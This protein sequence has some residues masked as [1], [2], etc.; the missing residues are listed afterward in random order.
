MKTPEPA[1][2]RV[3]NAFQDEH[4][5]LSNFWPAKVVLDGVTYPS[6]EHAYQ[7]AKTHP[8]ERAPF[9]RCTAAQA[10]KLG[11]EIPVRSGWSDEKVAIMRALIEQKFAPGSE[12]ARKLVATGDCQL[13]EGNSWGDTFWGVCRGTGQNLLGEILMDRRTALTQ[14]AEKL[15]LIEHPSSSYSPRTR[16]NATGA[17]LT[18]ALAV[19]FTTAGEKLT[20][21]AAGENYLGIP[22]SEDPVQAARL[23]YKWLRDHGAQTPVINIAGN[24]LYTL[25][26]H[27]WTQTQADRHLYT[28]LAKVHEHW[29]I[30]K[31][32]SGGQTGID[33]AGLTAALAL[34]IPAAGTLPT[35]FLQRGADKRDFTQSEQALRDTITRGADQLLWVTPI[36]VKG[37]IRVVS[38]RPGGSVAEADEVVIDGDRSNPVFGNRHHLKNWQD[39]E[40]RKQVIDAHFHLDFE[41]DM[42]T[43]GPMYQAM[44]EIALRVRNGEEIALRCWCAPLPCHLDA[45]AHG[46]MRMAQGLEPID[47]KAPTRSAPAFKL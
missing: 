19:D 32:I 42:R 47:P 40:E 1:A 5:W 16:A 15:E 13:V 46:I 36:P 17:D 28:A 21:K 3:I 20:H 6:V 31:I 18:V 4:R 35:G 29:P 25:A 34:G 41:P 8:S 44:Q 26:Q 37:H 10:K 45:V 38:K 2:G 24:G 39:A 33:Q 7:A 11:R 23:I 12:L 43:K 14:P 9:Q 30:R 22:L 27:G